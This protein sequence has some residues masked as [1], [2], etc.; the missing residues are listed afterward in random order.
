MKVQVT[1]EMELNK[2]PDD[3]AR[4]LARELVEARGFNVSRVAI[5]ATKGRVKQFVPKAYAP[6]WTVKVGD[7]TY[8][9]WDHAE[10]HKGRRVDLWMT[11]VERQSDDASIYRFDGSGVRPY[12]GDGKPCRSEWHY[13]SAYERVETPCSHPAHA[14]ENAA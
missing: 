10:G 5:V 3:A 4:D 14:A 7:R 6:G 11:P 8:V 12:H 13:K 1:V 2:L 9:V